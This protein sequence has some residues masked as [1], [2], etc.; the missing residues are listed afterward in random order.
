MKSSPK[1][2]TNHW[3][4]NSK[5]ES[6]HEYKDNIWAEDLADTGLLSSKNY[7]FKYS[8]CIIDVITKYAWAKPLKDKITKTVLNGFIETVN[9]SKLKPNKL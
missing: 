8:L 7:E 1:N 2:Y 9:K 6:V 5:E 3:L 4:K